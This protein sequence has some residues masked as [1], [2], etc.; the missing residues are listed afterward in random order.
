MT[1]NL[2]KRKQTKN[3]KISLYLE[4]YKGKTTNA[5]GK[6]RYIRE[7]EYLNMFLVD[8]P[9]TEADKQHNK[10]VLQLAKNIKNKREL[11][12]QSGVHGFKMPKS[13]NTN[14]YQYY[15]RIAE[16]RRNTP[17]YQTW[18][19]ILNTFKDFAGENITFSEITSIFCEKYLDYLQ[20]KVS[21]KGTKLKNSYINKHLNYL[22]IV[23]RQAINDK[24]ISENPLQN[25]KLLKIKEPEIIY[26]TLPELKQLV[27]TDFKYPVLKRAFIFA[28]LT[29]LRWS[30]VY[31]LQ[32]SE[33]KESD[34]KYLLAYRQKKTQEQNYLPLPEQALNYLGE[35]GFDTEKVFNLTNY[36]NSITVKLQAW[37]ELAG[38]KK[39]ITFH[40][41][42][43][44][45]A[46]LQLSFG[47]PIF[48]V[49][50]LLGHTSISST[51]KYANIVDAAK[52][53]AMNVIPN[54]L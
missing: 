17:S 6:S 37:C 47:T 51:M 35:R 40:S 22:F 12:L 32:W 43:H 14:F 10:E 3:G 11:E 27:K 15:H 2:R 45:F 29:G 52:V 54:I 24:I 36:D 4:I 23:V 7:Y 30:D 46:V 44:T 41:S 50:K 42:R 33:I 9:R 53:D 19:I 21:L 1:I 49:Q 25:I 39:K 48:T 18:R 8:N 34:G 28:C 26:L 31:K 38:V 5:D 16:K 13:K 20:N